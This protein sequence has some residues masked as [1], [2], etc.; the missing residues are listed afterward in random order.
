MTEDS[1]FANYK[2][3]PVAF[4]H[5]DGVRLWDVQG[6]EYLDFLAGIAVSSLGHSHPALTEA[7]SRQAGRY[8][9]VSNLFRIR[10]QE[11]AGELLVEATEGL[12]H[13]AFFCNSGAE[14]VEAAIK[15][16]RRYAYDRDGSG[17]RHRIVTA[18]GGFH[19]RTLGALAATATPAY[20]VGF[21][22]LPGGFASVP[23]GDLEAAA[24]EIDGS[25]CAVLIEAI[26]GEAGVIEPPDGYLEGLQALC[27]E[28]GALFILDEVQTGIGRLGRAY[29]FQHYGLEP[30]VVTLAKGLGGGVPVGAVL[31]RREV[32]SA[33]VPGTH[34][35]TFGGNALASAAVRAVLETVFDPDFL[36]RVVRAGEYLRALLGQLKAGGLVTEVR[37]QGL[38]TAIECTPDA[39]DVATRCLENGLIVNA[40]RTHS[41]RMLPPLVVHDPEI[42]RAVGIL[43]HCLE[44]QT[45]EDGAA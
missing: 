17:D 36:E 13:S 35:T 27:R 41:I 31:A 19:G 43:A 22:P 14:A 38:M 15:L 20:Q 10:E 24:G 1:L 45:L 34:G 28:R 4:S 18:E 9:H 40:P 11:R 21:G 33:L 44:A 32:A 7:I 16:A 23:F 29:G 2:R 12:L 42:E 39:A 3:A 37:G 6:R 8:L 5:G 25:T 26:Q 30:D